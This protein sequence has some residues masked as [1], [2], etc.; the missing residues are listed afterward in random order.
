MA[1]A[2]RVDIEECDPMFASS[3]NVCRYLAPDNLGEQCRF[4]HRSAILLQ[5]INATGQPRVLGQCMRVSVDVAPK[6][7]NAADGFHHLLSSL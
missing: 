5:R 2:T 4:R 7:G 6:T 3:N 1:G